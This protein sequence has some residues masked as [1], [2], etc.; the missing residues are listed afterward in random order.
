M[1]RLPLILLCFAW[2]FSCASLPVSIAG[3]NLGWGLVVFALLSRLCF[4]RNIPWSRH[5][6]AVEVP[7][8]AYLTAA[9]LACAL[10][11][12]PRYS[13]SFLVKDA[14]KVWIYA[15]Y[16][17]GLAALIEEG[18][19]AVWTVPVALAAGLAVSA[20]VGLWQTF[21]S[22]GPLW[23][24][25]RGFM[26]P[27]TFGE[28]MA[29]GA[30]GAF[31]Y[32][33]LSPRADRV[34]APAIA[35]LALSSLA[36][37]FSQT[38]GAILALAAGFFAIACFAAPGR[39]Q[40]RAAVAGVAS[41]IATF[42]SDLL[43]TGRSLIESISRQPAAANPQ[44]ARWTLWKVSF[45]MFLNH[46]LFGVGINNYRE[47]FTRYFSGTVDGEAAF[48]TAHNLYLHQTAERGLV[49]AAALAWLLIALWRRSL[50]RT[51]RTPDPVGIWAFGS[52]AAFLAMNCTEVALQ[53]EQLWMLFFLIWIFAEQRSQ[54]V[55]PAQAGA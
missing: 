9:A 21:S 53:V 7:L 15:V 17:I 5:H 14:H 22:A 20:T 36:L 13:F 51:R 39:C 12:L 31:C 32:A 43:P 30:L 3:S 45:R 8:L 46:P 44:L 1:A 42:A 34:R 50:Q 35:L 37:F 38:R 25:A 52:T 47:Q 4:G 10:G 18:P 6:S 49:G 33:E 19:A 28:Q 48:G 40:R 55:A 23:T 41:L 54:A 2:A 29:L 24:R 16:S 11:V 27:V 26:H